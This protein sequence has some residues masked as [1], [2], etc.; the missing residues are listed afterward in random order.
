MATSDS[1]RPAPPRIYTAQVLAVDNH[2][3]LEEGASRHVAGALRLGIGDRLVLF[4]GRGGEYSAKIT[5]AARKRVSVAVTEHSERCLESS[6]NIHLGVCLSRGERMDWVIQKATELG[7]GAITPL[8]S[9]RCEVRLS[10]ERLGKKMLH[11]QRVVTSACEQCGR[12]TLPPVHKP[13]TLPEWCTTVEADLRV[14][15]DPR[16][17]PATTSDSSRNHLNSNSNHLNSNPSRLAL[18]SGPEG[19]FSTAEIQVAASAGFQAL[20]L[21]PRIMRTETA[22]L[23]AIAVLQARWGDFQPEPLS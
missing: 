20:A 7:A 22:P 10:G 21:G 2:C 3:D 9:E 4:N 23:A 19:G 5:A 15:L 1:A 11:W 18:V 8:F 16:A 14:I 12:N 17:G 6:L 13:I